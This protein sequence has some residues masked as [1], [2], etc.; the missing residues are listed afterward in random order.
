MW[1]QTPDGRD[2]RRTTA[3]SLH[4]SAKVMVPRFVYHRGFVASVL[5]RMS[6]LDTNSISRHCLL[7]PSCSLTALSET[8]AIQTS[9]LVFFSICAFP[10]TEVGHCEG[11]HKRQ[12]QTTKQGQQR[13]RETRAQ[14]A[15][16]VG[17]YRQSLA[18]Q[19]GQVMS[20]LPVREDILQGML[21]SR[22]FARAFQP[23][24]SRRR[25]RLV[26]F[27]T[28]D[29][30]RRAGSRDTRHLARLALPDL[31]V[32]DGGRGP[33]HMSV[34]ASDH[35]RSVRGTSCPAAPRCWEPATPFRR[36]ASCR[37]E[38]ERW[39]FDVVGAPLE[40]QMNADNDVI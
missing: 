39:I 8:E 21:S 23:P 14:S 17:R 31:A 24:F 20:C 16:C 9:P 33:Q 32:A 27:Q 34:S 7:S 15:H 11:G 13:D 4:L 2:Q 10:S 22:L 40:R 6:R 12:N 36:V 18:F 19:V 3:C 35:P 26:T 38:P 30:L 29:Y 37:R 28:F 25:R 1:E 5:P